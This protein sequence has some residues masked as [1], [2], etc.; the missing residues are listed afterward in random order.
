MFRR[1]RLRIVA[2]IIL[3]GGGSALLGAGALPAAAAGGQACAGMAD[4]GTLGGLR[5]QGSAL[6]DRGEVTGTADL[7]TGDSHAFV[8][9]GGQMIDLATPRWHGELW[10]VGE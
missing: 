9:S 3:V 7:A 2:V 4:L 8:W 1:A 6:N 10:L 5:S